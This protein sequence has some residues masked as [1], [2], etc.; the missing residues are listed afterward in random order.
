MFIDQLF[1]LSAKAEI[2]VLNVSEEDYTKEKIVEIH[3]KYAGLLGID[4]EK[5][6]VI[7]AKIESELSELSEVEQKQ[8]LR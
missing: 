5:M 8:Y 6:I 7:C 2:V 4:M 1:L 3:K